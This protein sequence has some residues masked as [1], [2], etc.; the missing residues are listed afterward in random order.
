MELPE[1]V[2]VK[3]IK[4]QRRKGRNYDNIHEL[5]RCIFSVGLDGTITS[6]AE[7]FSDIRREIKQKETN[8]CDDVIGIIY[9]DEYVKSSKKKKERRRRR[10][11]RRRC[12]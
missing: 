12:E 4:G 3:K 2:K 5:L 6:D 8:T 1:P 11:S 7:E 9:G 10:R